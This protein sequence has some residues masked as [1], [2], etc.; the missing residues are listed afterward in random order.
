M[1]HEMVVGE[2]SDSCSNVT[3]PVILESPRR[4]ATRKEDEVSNHKGY[5]YWGGNELNLLK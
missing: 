5:I 4:R 3:V 1:F 2:D